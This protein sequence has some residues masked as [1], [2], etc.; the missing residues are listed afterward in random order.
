[1]ENVLLNEKFPVISDWQEICIGSGPE[2]ISFFLQRAHASGNQISSDVVI[3]VYTETVNDILQ[4]NVSV[5][6]IKTVIDSVKL[7]TMLVHWP[8][9]LLGCPTDVITKMSNDMKLTASKLGILP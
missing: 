1:M 8:H 7:R 9:Y 2:D 6:S 3:R 5:Q 4:K